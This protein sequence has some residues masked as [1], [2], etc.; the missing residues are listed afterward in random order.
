MPEVLVYDKS[1]SEPCKVCTGGVTGMAVRESEPNVSGCLLVPDNYC[2]RNFRRTTER[3][4]HKVRK[5]TVSAVTFAQRNIRFD[6]VL[7][8][9]A[10][11]IV[12][13]D[14][15][16]VLSPKRVRVPGGPLPSFL[17]LVRR[18]SEHARR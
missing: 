5:N 2:I 7:S 15:R 18:L 14:V 17:L 8:G 9:A 11:R 13:V 16:E 10:G 1:A 6:K 12:D 3:C 4:I